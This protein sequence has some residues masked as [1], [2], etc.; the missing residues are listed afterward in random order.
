VA[1][2]ASGAPGGD[3]GIAGEEEGASAPAT[4]PEASDPTVNALGSLETGGVVFGPD[5][6]IK[7]PMKVDY[8]DSVYSADA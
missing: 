7:T 2:E 8:V 6:D 3:T 1:A 4:G 5:D